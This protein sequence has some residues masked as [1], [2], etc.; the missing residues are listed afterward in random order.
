[1][2][3]R[4]LDGTKLDVSWET[5]DHYAAKVDEQ[6]DLLV[7]YTAGD[8]FIYRQ[9][10][11]RDGRARYPAQHRRHGAGAAALGAGCVG[12]GATHRRPVA[13]AS[14]VAERIAAGKLDVVDPDGQR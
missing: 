4:L 7:N 8:G 1:M 6:I 9:I 3:E 14:N 5:L 10:G 12:A 2:R 13:A 11:A